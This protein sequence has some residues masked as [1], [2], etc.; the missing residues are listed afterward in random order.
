[1]TYQDRICD[2]IDL[3]A[4]LHVLDGMVSPTTEERERF[5]ELCRK[6]ADMIS[7]DKNRTARSKASM[8]GSGSDHD[9]LAMEAIDEITYKVRRIR[10]VKIG[11]GADQVGE[12]G[13]AFWGL[14]GDPA[15]RYARKRAENNSSA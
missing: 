7:E 2:Y 12:L 5:S 8:A 1:M 11:H 9:R 10:H 3:W 15:V 13:M 6:V 14:S 4:K